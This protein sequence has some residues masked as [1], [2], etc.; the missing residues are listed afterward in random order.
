MSALRLDE[1][2]RAIELA[3]AE[4]WGPWHADQAESFFDL[5]I[6][7]SYNLLSML[8][9][10]DR[11]DE[12]ERQ[13][14]AICEAFGPSVAAGAIE[15]FAL[16]LP[17]GVQRRMAAS[18][19]IDRDDPLAAPWREARTRLL[20]VVE[21]E[22]AWSEAVGYLRRSLEPASPEPPDRGA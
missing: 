21:A 13:F 4:A 15:R 22:P 5:K 9:S 12:A 10:A 2:A 17:D 3:Y 16:A 7:P 6:R 20:E 1:L 11:F 8:A 14:D 18:L 19:S